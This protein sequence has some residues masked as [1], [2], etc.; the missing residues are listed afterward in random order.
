MLVVKTAITSATGSA[1]Y[2][3]MA[4]FSKKCGSIYMSGMSRII[5]LNIARKS[6]VFAFPMAMNV[7]WQA[8]CMPK[9]PDTAKYILIAHEP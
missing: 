3:A 9:I 2:T 7:C 5:F 4:L 8:I 6:D 1:I